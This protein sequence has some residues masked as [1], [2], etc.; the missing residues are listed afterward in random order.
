MHDHTNRTLIV[1]MIIILIVILAVYFLPH[2]VYYYNTQPTTIERTVPVRTGATVQTRTYTT[3]P[4]TT[5]SYQ[6]TTTTTQN[7]SSG[8]QF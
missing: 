5:S 7:T 1:I 8:Q 4:V 2:G 6:E 3:T